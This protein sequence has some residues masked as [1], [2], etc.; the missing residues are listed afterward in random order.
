MGKKNFT[1]S[2]TAQPHRGAKLSRI[3]IIHARSSLFAPFVDN[4]PM[5]LD[6]TTLVTIP[7]GAKSERAPLFAHARPDRRQLTTKILGERFP[8]QFVTCWGNIIRKL[9]EMFTKT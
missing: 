6:S 8:G 4:L 2:V 9:P 3:G 7:C 5:G 1:E